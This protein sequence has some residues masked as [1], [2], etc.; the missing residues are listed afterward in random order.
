[1]RLYDLLLMIRHLNLLST[2]LSNRG[3]A[4]LP[5]KSK[6]VLGPLEKWYHCVN[7]QSGI[8]KSVA[9]IAWKFSQAVP[10]F[11]FFFLPQ[12]LV[13]VSFFFFFNYIEPG[14]PEKE[15]R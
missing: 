7:T 3:G 12:L 2:A 10:N 11:F 8:G 4:L 14:I 6:I 5:P 13:A 9:P 15:A 1:M